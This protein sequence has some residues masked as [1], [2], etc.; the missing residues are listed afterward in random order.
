MF[1]QGEKNKRRLFG[2]A[3]LDGGRPAG[4]TLIEVIVSLF[5]LTVLMLSVFTLIKLSLQMTDN[6]GKY[7]EAIEIANQK[8]EIIRNLPY[9]D[10]GVVGGIPNGIVPAVETVSRKGNFTVNTYIVYYDDDYDGLIG[11]STPDTIPN[12]YKIATVKVSW[13][14]K[15]GEKHVTVFSK[16]I[17]RT[18]ETFAGYGLLKI[19]VGNA[20]AQ[21]VANANVRVVNNLVSPA[22][23]VTNLTNSKGLLYLPATS[24]AQ[25]YEITITKT[26]EEPA[27][28]YGTDRTY[29]PATSKSPFHLSVTAGNMTQES[30]TIDKLA[31][32][33]IRTVSA[34]LPDNWQVNETIAGRD[35][36]GVNFSRDNSDNMYFAWQS[37]DAGSS[38]VYAQKYDSGGAKQWAS[39]YKISTTAYQANPDIAVIASGNSFVVWQDNS[40]TLKAITYHGPV[41]R[42]ARKRE[43]LAVSPGLDLASLS[44]FNPINNVF[45][46]TEFTSPYVLSSSKIVPALNFKPADI[47]NRITDRTADIFKNS[48]KVDP[49]RAAGMI[50]Q[51][52]ISP[53]EN[54]ANTL[55]ASFDSPPTAGNVIIAVAM[56]R[57]NWATFNAP[58]NAAGTFTE[59][60][61]SNSNWYL[62]VGIWYKVA[63]AG[64]PSQ[65]SITNS[66]DIDG[67]VLMILEVSGLDTSDL[68]D[69]VVKHDQTGSNSTTAT[70]N[71]TAQSEA[72]GFA[73][74]AIGW[75]DN[76][77]NTP[78]SGD[79]S[80]G[81]SDAWVQTLWKDWSFGHDGSLALATMDIS[82]A[83]NQSAALTL[84][85]GGTEQR[86][87]VLAVF[88]VAVP[89]NIT[90]SAT[91]TQISSTTVFTNNEYLGGA[92]V[93]TD[94]TGA[95]NITDI[96][97]TEYGTVDARNNLDNI[98]LY[99]DLDASAPY[100]CASESYDGSEPQFGLTDTDGFSAANG[101]STFSDLV[102]ISTT[103]TMCVYTVL[104]VGGAQ[105]NENIKIRI[106]NPSVDVVTDS[107][108]VLPGTS[109]SLSGSINI[110]T[111][112]EMQQAHYRWRNDDGSES[113]ASWAE[114][115][116]TPAIITDS[117]V[118][119]RFSVANGGTLSTGPIAYRL[120]YGEKITTCAAIAAW[121]ALPYSD[122]ADWR[123]I[124]S[125]NFLND[126]ITTNNSGLTDE[127][128]I[129]AT[130]AMKDTDNQTSAI[131]LS[132][133]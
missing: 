126:E 99:Y 9:D 30:F 14:S 105:A 4:F 81:S 123:M 59:A 85:G 33:R 116:D 115:E 56:H 41:K 40:K 106:D 78:G 109:V 130:G 62:D 129:F 63:G 118:R 16:I 42:F 7:V 49:A 44:I 100:D 67:G 114:A 89:D 11:S 53:I 54:S 17:P 5:V 8:M 46:L 107:G 60:V 132:G 57:N 84:T 131:T 90:V 55:T 119:L 112:A 83:D 111:P 101:S 43:P 98:K 68:V 133:A 70:T 73:I 92:F 12:D 45:G 77:F 20:S 6:N 36:S 32:L 51:T 88:K 91:G 15:A 102:G 76:D 19:Y 25:G 2:L 124:D 113:G 1:K 127:N 79:W 93:L 122:A 61:Y 121:T 47:F 52:K 64:E 80:S 10:V 38:Y 37:Y 65:V 31:H 110:N 96:T 74:A 50:A 97:I 27:F 72:S 35:E 94:N 82:A 87:S 66:D 29:D 21:P 22:I 3:L 58:V 13:Q 95:R 104:D 48:F 28:Y 69:V 71:S 75:G 120:E 26:D 117:V 128:L 103:Q 23:D 108:T 125:T 39:D 86:N 24:S 34:S 18:V